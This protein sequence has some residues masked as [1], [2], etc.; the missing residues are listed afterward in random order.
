MIGFDKFKLVLGVDDI[1]ITDVEKYT[2]KVK[3]GEIIEMEYR[4]DYPFLLKIKID[5]RK[6][7]STIE[8]TGKVLLEEYHNLIRLSNIKKCIENI[9][10][11]GGCEIK[12]YLSAEV[13]KCD[14]ANDYNVRNVERLRNFI[15]TNLSNYKKYIAEPQS[16][17][18]FIIRKN[19][20]TKRC[21]KRMTIY[22]KGR[23]MIKAENLKFLETYYNGNNPFLDKC[24]FEINL[25]SKN[26]I[27]KSLKI[28]DTSLKTVFLSAQYANPIYEFMNE[29][30]LKN[31]TP[32]S[33][34]SKVAEY[35]T[36]CVLAQNDF[37]L[38]R[39]RAYYQVNK[40]KGTKIANIMKPIIACYEKIK[41]D[42]TAYTRSKVLELITT[43]TQITSRMILD[44][45]FI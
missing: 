10:H 26:Q 39:V 32:Y 18:N 14:S 42:K 13:C 12:N 6:N 43:E 33:P 44:C 2:Q 22:D 8:F 31:D 17:G 24:R 25:N 28:L 15:Y 11:F 5:Y 45:A 19:V 4:Q 40:S 9:N 38:D 21:K 37:D 27:R 36:Y 1:R 3:D 16:N 41:N 20:N 23:E 7:E 29:I 30:L 35:K 34:P